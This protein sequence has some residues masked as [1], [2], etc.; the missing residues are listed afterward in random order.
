MVHCEILVYSQKY[1]Y[2]IQNVCRAYICILLVKLLF[3]SVFAVTCTSYGIQDLH[4][5]KLFWPSE[6]THNL[7]V[8]CVSL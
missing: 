6:V 4:D 7:S 2:H 1:L 8:E 3:L 5:R